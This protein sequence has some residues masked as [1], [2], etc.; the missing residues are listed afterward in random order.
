[1]ISRV[2]ILFHWRET[3]LVAQFRL[4]S[5]SHVEFALMKCATYWCRVIIEDVH[6]NRAETSSTMAILCEYDINY[7]NLVMSFCIIHLTQEFSLFYLV[8]DTINWTF[9]PNI[10]HAKVFWSIDNSDGSWTLIYI[11]FIIFLQCFLK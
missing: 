3:I 8:F 1:M 4:Q 5:K 2:R 6:L 10:L 7:V 11:L 9:F